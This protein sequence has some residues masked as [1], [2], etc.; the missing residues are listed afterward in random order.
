M[1]FPKPVKRAKALRKRLKKQR[2]TTR[3]KLIR[4]CDEATRLLVKALAGD[5]CENCGAAPWLNNP[6][7]CAH[8]DGRAKTWAL[9]WAHS[10]VFALCAKCHRD[11]GSHLGD[12][13]AFREGLLSWDAWILVGQKVREKPKV[14]V[15]EMADV[16]VGLKR[17]VFLQGGRS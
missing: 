16:L 14:S 11:F 12:F 4:E 3:A 9:R 6:L 7:E 8:G 1:N 2:A 10:N 13:A 17:G 5:R 15:A